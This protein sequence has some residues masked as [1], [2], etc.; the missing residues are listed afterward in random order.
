[1]THAQPAS[2][3][4]RA[5]SLS[6]RGVV[7]AVFFAFAIGIG[8]W[9]GAI[10]A[11]MRQAGLDA[12][13][14]GI[15]LTLHTGAY[16]AAM[17][18]GGQLAHV[19]APRRLMLAA[20]GANALCFGVLFAAPSP[21]VLTLALAAMGLSA[22]L[23]DLAM[24]TEGTAVERE[25][26]RPVL[27][28]M[29]AA[30]SGAFAIGAFAGSL[31]AT[32]AGPRWC[33]LPVLV[34][35]LP[36][37]LAVRRLGARPPAP[38]APLAVPARGGAVRG[39][40]RIGIV[41]GLTIGAEMAAQMWSARFLERQAIELAAYAGAGAAF[42]AGFQAL[43][44][45]LGDALRR[46]LGDQRVITGSLLVAAVGFATVAGSAHFALSLLG[47]ALVGLGTACVVPCCFALVAR[48]DA[49]R[50][51]AALGVASLIAGSI[52][53]PTPLLL[54]F[55]AAAYSDA[56]AFAGVALG[57]VV[58]TMLARLGLREPTR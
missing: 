18:G 10:P 8:L 58:A 12:A 36:V 53:L 52:R 4:R 33:A 16:I 26:G 35:T 42:F 30:A 56:I 17:A 39:V 43:V 24:N 9:A 5:L 38:V 15:A 44:R 25:L 22:G 48:Q 47:F 31:I 7:T 50:A 19:V 40:A 45:L 27:L 3:S 13:G 6:P 28:S 23:L 11:L 2:L 55:V 32:G 29:H 49:E 34:V 54:G 37:A 1:M 46:R 57:L 41:L 14:L 51:A 21:L 20:L